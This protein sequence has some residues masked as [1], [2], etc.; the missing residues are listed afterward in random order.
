MDVPYAVPVPRELHQVELVLCVQSARPPDL[1]GI[2]ESIAIMDKC[3][4][5]FGVCLPSGGVGLSSAELTLQC[6]VL[7]THMPRSRAPFATDSH[8]QTEDLLESLAAPPCSF[9]PPLSARTDRDLLQEALA[10]L[11]G[12]APVPQAGIGLTYGVGQTQQDAAGHW[13]RAMLVPDWETRCPFHSTG[14]PSPGCHVCGGGL[15]VP[16]R[17]DDALWRKKRK[18]HHVRGSDA[19]P[20]HLRVLILERRLMSSAGLSL[21]L[22]FEP[23]PVAALLRELRYFR[24]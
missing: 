8:A 18:L 1:T 13:R 12:W 23:Q 20:Q 10:V 24:C 2:E 14:E 3:E 17:G 6:F 15:C 22:L 11:R 16:V 21:R 7:N 19:A 4:R 9:A 5:V